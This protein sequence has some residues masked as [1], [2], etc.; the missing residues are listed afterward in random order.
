MFYTLFS[1]DFYKMPWRYAVSFTVFCAPLLL[2]CPAQAQPISETK[3]VSDDLEVLVFR[4][5]AEGKQLLLWI[6]PS[7]GFRQGHSDMSQLLSKQGFEVWQ[8]DINEALFLPHNS[9]VMRELDPK[10]VSDLIKTAHTETG[11]Q[12]VLV[13]GSYGAIPTLRGAHEWLLTKPDSRYLLGVIL[14]SPNVY[15]SIPPLG[16]E[17]AFL[18]IA[19]ATSVPVVIF[20]GDMNSNRW[21]VDKLTEALRSG[22]SSV[23]IEI[24]KDVVGLFYGEDRK[25]HIEQYFHNFTTGMKNQIDWFNKN[26]Y[27]LEARKI[28][29]AGPSSGTGLDSRLKPYKGNPQPSP[30]TLTDINGKSYNIID[31]KNRVT[32]VNFWATWCTPCIREIPSLNKLRQSMQGKPFELISINYA[33]KAE[34]IKEFMEMVDVEFPVLLDEQGLE[35]AKWKVIAFP[36]TFV[37]GR[38]G[39][40]HYGVNAGIEWDTPDVINAVNKMLHD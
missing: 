5:P 40:I 15:Q 30:I 27:A 26:P 36:S 8:A 22:G 25:P 2:I 11:K 1:I 33:E 28:N 35:A 23:R 17:P 18:P 10:Y 9:T 29:T 39:L 19:Y 32:I 21:Q 31:F 34:T 12:I 14:F 37:I 24:M 3:I 38:D 6:A 20:Q 13:S 4:Y 7:F 16:T